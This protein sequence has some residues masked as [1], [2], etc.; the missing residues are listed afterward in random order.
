[1]AKQKPIIATYI[2]NKKRA[3][4]LLGIRGRSTYLYV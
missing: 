4:F 1:M 2:L 3:A